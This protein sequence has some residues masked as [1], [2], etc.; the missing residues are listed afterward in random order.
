M[1]SSPR[2]FLTITLNPAIDWTLTLDQLRPG[3]VHRACAGNRS[4]GG[5]GINVATHLALAG[6]SVTV[7]G[8]LGKGNAALFDRHFEQHQLRDRFIRVEGE[9]RTGIKLVA[10]AASQTTDINTPGF[11]VS[12][13]SLN[14]LASV[15]ER[16]AGEH[17]WVVFSGSLPP[18]VL[19]QD[20]RELLR[21]ARLRGAKIAVDSS[22]EAL[23]AALS[24]DIHLLKPNLEE[25][26]QA[27][28]ME[29][30]GQALLEKAAREWSL[31]HKASLLLTKGSAGSSLFHAGEQCNLCAP[32]VPVF[33]TVGAGDAAL[34]G[35]LHGQSL[36]S[37][38]EAC[39]EMAHEFA[40]RQLSKRP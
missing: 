25:W 26:A 36:G 23:R 7:S 29:A 30:S 14:Q 40:A 35:W 17:E 39:L 34:A 33:S 18:G 10:H 9:T 12:H 1:E 27:N 6:H 11:P 20:F 16:L 19:A 15:L 38:P 32:Q 28:G 22:G 2:R 13:A 21:S 31:E 37:S 3:Q 24:E 4:A 8:F 5:K